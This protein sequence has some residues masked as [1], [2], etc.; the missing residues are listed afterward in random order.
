VSG[1]WKV[2]ELSKGKLLLT[3]ELGIKH[4]FVWRGNHKGT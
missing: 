4:D 2:I 3:Q 1:F